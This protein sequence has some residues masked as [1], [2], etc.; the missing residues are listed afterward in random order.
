MLAIAH[1]ACAGESIW[2]HNGSKLK[3]IS[4]GQKRSAVYFELRDGLSAA[5]I[6]V[7]TVLF[8]GYRKGAALTGKSFLFRKGCQ[9]LAFDVAATIT[10]E[11]SITLTGN[12]PIRTAGCE[13]GSATKLVTLHLDFNKEATDK[14]AG[15][16]NVSIPSS[17]LS[18]GD[19]PK[20]SL[21]LDAKISAIKKEEQAMENQATNGASFTLCNTTTESVSVAVYRAKRTRGWIYIYSGQCAVLEKF[22]QPG[23]LH[24]YAISK[25]SR[26][27]GP[28]LHCVV[29]NSFSRSEDQD[30]DAGK[31]V[32]FISRS[33]DR[34]E[35]ATMNLAPRAG[36]PK[37]EIEEGD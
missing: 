4:D 17:G 15:G 12:A 5:G 14:L 20:P 37:V 25:S 6:S 23:T 28:Y 18:S 19:I 33:L 9:P 3:W 27:T 2:D 26:W 35:H 30:C 11:Q 13:I 16:N 22:S 10:D 7:G 21:S 36:A 8:E 29:D 32:G 31:F 34:G 24:Y 1:P